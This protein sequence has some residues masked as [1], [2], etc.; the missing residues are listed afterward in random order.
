M[1]IEYEAKILHINTAQFVQ[2]VAVK[3]WC[4]KSKQAKNRRSK[5]SFIHYPI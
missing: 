2:Q 1:S 5:I 3:F 4:D